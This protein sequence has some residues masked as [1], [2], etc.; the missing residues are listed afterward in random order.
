MSLKIIE[1][2][3]MK[4]IIIDDENKARSLMQ[5]L[6]KDH[7]HEITETLEADDLEGGVAKIKLE[8]PDLVFLDIEMPNYSG[9]QILEFFDGYDINFQIIFTTAYNDYALQ[10]FKLS[11]I[12]YLLKPIDPKEL[13][14]AV[15][16]AQTA[17]SQNKI[18]NKLD[19]L[20][21][22]FKQLS[23]NK[24]ALD[25]PK[26]II[27]VSHEDIL[28]FEADG[29][30]TKVYMKN[31]DPQLI[32]K[33]LRHFVDQLAEK[34]IFYKP[35]RSYLV[36]LKYIKQF[37]KNDGFYLV[38]ENNKTVPISKDK[39]DEFLQMVNDVF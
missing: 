7:C 38:M 4:A 2:M 14:S 3:P 13:K 36:N 30:Y 20:R 35:H 37:I 11:A 23:I 17:L 5:A 6:I 19:D 24:L 12:D 22:A 29:M 32:C 9:L 33:P 18:N 15:N 8:K 39:K 28:F 27:F 10:A 25:I 1:R 31:E 34:P 26:G 21:N 16:K